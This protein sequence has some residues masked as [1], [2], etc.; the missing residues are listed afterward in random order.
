MNW[1]KIARCSAV[2]IGTTFVAV[3]AVVAVFL[4]VRLFGLVL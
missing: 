2:E 4:V 3:V 1:I